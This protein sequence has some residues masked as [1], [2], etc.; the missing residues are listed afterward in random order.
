MGAVS[1]EVLVRRRGAVGRARSDLL[2][3]HSALSEAQE[4]LAAVSAQISGVNQRVTDL[5]AVL[6]RLER[7]GT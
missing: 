2:D 7:R 3:L 6:A 1:H 5:W 4:Q